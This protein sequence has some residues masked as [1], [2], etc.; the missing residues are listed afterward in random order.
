M[1]LKTAAVPGKSIMGARSYLPCNGFFLS[2]SGGAGSL[3]IF[4]LVLL[5][6]SCLL[7]PQ[8]A[9]VAN[10]VF[11]PAGVGLRSF[12]FNARCDKLLS[13]KAMALVDF[14]GN[15][16]AYIGQVQEIVAVHRE[17]A[18]VSQGSHCMTHAGF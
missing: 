14:F 10:D 17:K 7:Q 16:P 2:P 12:R 3:G 6:C 9:L 5:L 13:E 8:K 1:L 18:A 11:N 4:S 15:C